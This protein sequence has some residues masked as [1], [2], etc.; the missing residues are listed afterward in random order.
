[1]LSFQFLISGIFK[2]VVLLSIL[3]TQYFP[4]L[5]GEGNSIFTGPL[6][7]FSL[8]ITSVI[9][10]QPRLIAPLNASLLREYKV[11]KK[12]LL[13]IHEIPEILFMINSAFQLNVLS[14]CLVT[15]SVLPFVRIREGLIPVLVFL[16]LR[17]TPFWHDIEVVLSSII[18]GCISQTTI[19]QLL[20]HWD[21]FFI[22]NFY[23][24]STCVLVL[25]IGV[26]IVQFIT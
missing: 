26:S 24:V 2:P 1:M 10:Y 19:A 8:I 12:P 5:Y 13:P 7:G 18:C 3:S 23:L 15:A 20:F 6:I 9:Y 17:V 4:W 22:P 16:V 11:Y 21:S 25:F 14:S